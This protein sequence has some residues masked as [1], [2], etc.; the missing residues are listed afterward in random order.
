MFKPISITLISVFFT[1]FSF[2]AVDCEHF[3]MER[4]QKNSEINEFNLDV[5]KLRQKAQKLRERLFERMDI[6]KAL[7]G[8]IGDSQ[9]ERDSAVQERALL[10]ENMSS[11]EL[12]ITNQK[13]EENRLYAQMDDAQRRIDSSPAGSSAR[14]SAMRD[15]KRAEKTLERVQAQIQMLAAQIAPMREEK[16]RVNQRIQTIS[17][18]IQSLNEDLIK[19]QN[20]KPSVEFLREKIAEVE[21]Q[22]QNSD[23][24]LERLLAQLDEAEEKILMCAT[25]NQK[26][27]LVLNLAREISQTGCKNYQ[28]KP[29]ENL[30]EREAQDEIFA[31]MC[32]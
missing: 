7:E 21:D 17:N 1:S 16:N 2:A 5:E 14:R 10:A 11:V 22:I 23:V 31:S 19:V 4:D 20:E 24:S 32:E 15:F 3:K 28:F 29:F 8:Q 9:A 26:Y 6:I 12:E 27:P 13:A 25:Y 18:N 30:S